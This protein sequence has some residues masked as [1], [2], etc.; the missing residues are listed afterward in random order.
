[1]I[2]ADVDVEYTYEIVP[3]HFG[4]DKW[5]KMAKCILRAR[6]LCITP[7]S[8]SVRRA[9]NGCGTLRLAYRSPLRHSAVPQDRLEA[10]GTTSDVLLV[11][12]P[13]SSP[14]RWP[15][16][17]AKFVPAG[18]DLV[19]QIHYTTKGTAGTD[20]TSI[21]LVFAKSPP[22]QRVITL[23]L[24]DH[25]FIIPPGADDF[26]VE[27]QG[28]L[29]NDATL[30]SLFPHMHLR[31]KRFEYDI[32][33]P[34]GS[35][36]TLLRVN[37]HFHWQLSY[38]LAEPRLLKAEPGC[39]RSPGMTTRRV[40]RIILIQLRQSHGAT[41]LIKKS[42]HHFL[43]SLVAPCDCRSWIRI[44]RIICELSYQATARNLV[45]AFSNL[46]SASR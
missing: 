37:Y 29:P 8:T 14:D 6:R 31:G 9:R 22:Q 36:E 30:L 19:F 7:W 21:G 44:M 45:P 17:M 34:D 43:I 18:S 24:N 3:T 38:R 23:Q 35:I 11:Y 1:M 12:A 2:P 15:D 40:I 25:A 4:E 28:T 46:G 33:Q 26:R 42:N 10:H 5:I 16:G 20:Q 13:G 39:A 32:V 41:R 27:V